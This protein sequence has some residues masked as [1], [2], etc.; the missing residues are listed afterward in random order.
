MSWIARTTRITKNLSH[1]PFSCK[2]YFTQ[3]ITSR[4][5]NPR[6]NNNFK[7]IGTFSTLTAIITTTGIYSY[8]N[9]FEN[10]NIQSDDNKDS[11]VVF[12]SVDPLPIKITTPLSTTYDLIGYGIREVSFLKFKVYA[13][14]L[15]IAEDDLK[16]VKKIFNSKFIETFYEDINK[17]ESID[18]H[19][20]N[21][22]RALNDP[23]IS[24]I[25]IRNLL[26]SGVRF[27]A[28]ICAIRN[29]DLSHLRDGFIRTIK[30]NPNY[31]KY[32]KSEDESIGERITN[33]L[34]DLRNAFNSAKMTAKKNSLVFMEID[35]NQFLKITIETISKSNT[36]ERNKPLCIGTIKEPLIVELLFE[37][38]AGAE[39]PL[40]QSVQTLTA[41]N[42]VKLID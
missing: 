17:I 12:K 16:L 7:N 8:L 6:V 10:N 2:R 41:E 18:K 26:S 27:T 30:N 5:S 9:S 35:E 22:S 33:G 20:E 15:Y 21:L 29:T 11:I 19:K 39:K 13:L 36:N 14:G 32:M 4:I 28:R 24:N 34:D 23:Q 38:Y 37:S 40:V 3:N 31:S 42:L 25:L 1:S